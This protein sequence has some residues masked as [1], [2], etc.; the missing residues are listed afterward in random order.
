MNKGTDK[1]PLIY[2]T[3]K[4]KHMKAINRGNVDKVVEAIKDHVIDLAYFYV[5]GDVY[6][7]DPE[8]LEADIDEFVTNACNLYNV[9]DFVVRDNLADAGWSMFYAYANAMIEDEKEQIYV[10]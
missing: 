6:Q 10:R 8:G 7:D 2:K 9:N 3:G 4:E 5:S 1:L